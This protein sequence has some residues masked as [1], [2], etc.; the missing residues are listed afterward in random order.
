M[1]KTNDICRGNKR[2]LKYFEKSDSTRTL[3]TGMIIAGIA[4]LLWTWFIWWS[5]LFYI[6]GLVFIPTGIVFV[7]IGS[8]GRSTDEEIDGLISKLSAEADIDPERDADIIK[9]Q[10]R[11]PPPEVISGYDYADGKMFKKA[12]KKN[13]VRTEIFKKAT[14]IAKND[15]LYVRYAAVNIPFESVECG[16]FEIP[17]GE[18]EDIRVSSERRTVH[19]L[20]NSFSVKYSRFE[21]ISGGECVLSLPANVSATLDFFISEVKQKR[22][23]IAEKNN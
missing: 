18:I 15:G 12:K 6:L 20:K 8:V 17:Y 13:V 10:L 19:F 14:L 2:H 1:G 16:A 11:R 5:Y 7:V 9:K 4:M 23:S 21:I 22:D 3:G